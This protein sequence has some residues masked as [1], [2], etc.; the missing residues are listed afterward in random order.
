MAA[1]LSTGHTILLN[2]GSSS[3]KSTIG[4]ALQS[5]L[6]GDWL[7]TGIDVLIWMLPV[8]LTWSPAGISVADGEIHRG[9]AF[10]RAYEGFQHSVA[11]LCRAGRNVVVDDVL[12][13]GVVGQD[14]WK[15]S[16]VGIDAVWVGVRCEAGLA[17]ARESERGDRPP[18]IA[19]HYADRVHVGV[20]YDIEVDTGGASLEDTVKAIVG[21]LPDHWAV[22]P[23]PKSG[24]EALPA[25]SAWGADGSRSLAPWE[26]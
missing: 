24:R 14:R 25:R 9:P 26:R 19:G 1:H 18:G 4:R 10:L 5:E 16:M 12:T 21:A 6:E 11:A 8:E 2:G 20:D 13:D 17:A 23:L 3:G 7:L 15:A 22:A